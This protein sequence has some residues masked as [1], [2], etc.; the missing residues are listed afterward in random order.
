M[1]GEVNE[2]I[3]TEALTPRGDFWVEEL[4]AAKDDPDVFPSHFG[5]ELPALRLRDNGTSPLTARLA[6]IEQQKRA[7]VT[8]RLVEK[9][10]AKDAGGMVY[11]QWV[12]G[13][14]IE[15]PAARCFFISIVLLNAV[16]IG[17][18]VRSLVQNCL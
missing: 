9:Q 7:P 16:L 10:A 15:S 14:T 17:L 4:E 12:L 13:E 5:I 1:A 6:H 11:R 18:R 2:A 3:G 8:A